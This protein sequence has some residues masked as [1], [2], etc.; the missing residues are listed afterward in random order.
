MRP[1][2]SSEIPIGARMVHYYLLPTTYYL[3]LT[4]YYLLLTSSIFPPFYLLQPTVFLILQSADY[5]LK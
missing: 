4:T 2:Q 3:L 1:Y 5:T